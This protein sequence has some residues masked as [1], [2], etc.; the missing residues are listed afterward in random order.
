[1]HPNGPGRGHGHT[2]HVD[3]PDP[4]RPRWVFRA[5]SEPDPRFSL[6]NERTFLAW[7]RTSLALLAGGVALEALDLPIAD[8]WASISAILLVV[9]GILSPVWAWLGWARAERAART[10]SPLPAPTGSTMLAIG[11]VVAGA[12][13]LVGA[14]V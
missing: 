6:A 9:L 1:M 11:V 14:L 2:E 12:A 8:P 13:A 10:A 7:I 4:R 5:G 3:A